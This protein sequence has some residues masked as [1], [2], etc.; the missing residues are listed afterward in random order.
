MAGVKDGVSVGLEKREA[1]RISEL[2]ALGQCQ[3]TS[4]IWSGPNIEASSLC[5]EVPKF[6][7]EAARQ[8]PLERRVPCSC[9][10]RTV[11]AADGEGVRYV[12]RRRGGKTLLERQ[13]LS[14]AGIHA[15]R[16]GKGRLLSQ[17]VCELS[18]GLAVVVDSVASPEECRAFEWQ[19]PGQRY[20][21]RPVVTVGINQP[22]RK[23]SGIRSF[24]GRHNDRHIGVPRSDVQIGLTPILFGKGREASVPDP[25]YQRKIGFRLPLVLT[26]EVH[27]IL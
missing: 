5:A 26:V 19:F 1:D 6:G 11:V 24:R 12:L 14:C 16:G 22:A 15:I 8:I 18:V 2:I 17:S 27:L 23:G 3:R 4:L 21:G 9:V 20:T 25:K 7:K 10:G 13:D